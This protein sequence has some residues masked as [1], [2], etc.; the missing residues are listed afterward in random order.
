MPV[1]S[2]IILLGYLLEEFC[3]DKDQC[4]IFHL[5][6]ISKSNRELKHRCSSDMEI[7]LKETFFLLVLANRWEVCVTS[8]KK[9]LIGGCPFVGLLL[10][11][12]ASVSIACTAD[13]L[14][15]ICS[16]GYCLQ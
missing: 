1:A 8:Q 3:L 6:V 14:Q 11:T 9:V 10:F 12:L 7:K 5:S 2:I 13:G 16:E 4:L 15:S